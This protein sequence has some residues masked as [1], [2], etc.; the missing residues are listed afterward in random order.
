MALNIF[1]DLAWHGNPDETVNLL[2]NLHELAWWRQRKD[3]LELWRREKA[4]WMA[5]SSGHIDQGPHCILR[6]NKW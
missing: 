6:N 3:G 5:E 2:K 1:F 4:I